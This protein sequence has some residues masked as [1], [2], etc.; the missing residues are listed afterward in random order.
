[1]ATAADGSSSE[2]V[3]CHPALLDVPQPLGFLPTRKFWRDSEN[4]RLAGLPL[5][6]LGGVLVIVITLLGPPWWVG[7]LAAAAGIWLM[8]GLL[9]RYIRDAARRR[10]R[11]QPQQGALAEDR[12]ETSR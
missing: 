6:I 8:L 7:G 12:G 2:E 3:E 11:S 9:E 1:M 10:F 5:G 4:N